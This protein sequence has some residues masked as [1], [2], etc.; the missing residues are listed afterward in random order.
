AE[1]LARL[2]GPWMLSMDGLRDGSPRQKTL[3]SAIG[4]SYGLLTPTEQT[5][6]TRLAVFV[7]GCTLEAAELLCGADAALSPSLSFSLSP[8]QVLDGI[9]SL[10]DKSLLNLESGQ[11]G[12]SRYVMLETVREYASERLVAVGKAEETQNRHLTWCLTI[13]ASAVPSLFGILERVSW[14][15]IGAEIHNLRAGLEWA[16]QRNGAAAL[17]LVLATSRYLANR[18]FVREARAWIGRVL[19]LPEAAEATLERAAL[20]YCKG[21]AEFLADEITAAEASISESLALSRDLNLVSGQAGAHYYLGRLA[22]MA[23]DTSRAEMHL[24]AATSSFLEAG[25]VIDWGH[26]ISV[27]AEI[28]MF[29]GDLRRSRALHTQAV[30]RDLP[31]EQRHQVFWSVGGLAEVD[32]VEGDFASAQ[33]L[34]EECLALCRQ[35]DNP[36]E[37]A[38]PLTCLG[39]IA[40]R[41]RD[42]TAAH[43]Y[44]DAALSLGRTAD[45]YWRVAIVRADL[46]DLAVAE[47][48]PREA[49]RLYQDSLPIL[50]QRGIFALPQGSL[51]LACLASAVGQHEVAAT[52]LG[53]CSIA[54]ENG[55]E[56]LFPITQA[57]FDGTLTA[58]KVALDADAFEAA[59]VI[60]RALRPQAAIAWGL[61]CRQPSVQGAK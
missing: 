34:A 51:R 28:A 20:L 1:L 33:R 3:R 31:P 42:F 14:K 47:G 11:H 6:F 56:V 43:A 12:E 19:N 17:R 10:L 15:Q 18:G 26:V 59:W 38:W 22:S 53:A 32:L 55:L 23:G 41:C 25:D 48:R 21:T 49:L 16:L 2:H 5:L 44:L 4:W 46:G 27:L 13:A 29:R 54:V 24:E 45:S 30:T 36:G 40:I 57:D 35:R 7:G 60:G 39:E 61:R 58:A 8:P 52:L 9:A 37:I 50:L